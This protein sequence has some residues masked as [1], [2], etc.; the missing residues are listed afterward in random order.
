MNTLKKMIRACIHCLTFI[1]LYYKEMSDTG[2]GGETTDEE[3]LYN[4]WH[5]KVK[6]NYQELSKLISDR[7]HILK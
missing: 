6:I 2:K 3:L 1:H 7:A 5:W 4:V